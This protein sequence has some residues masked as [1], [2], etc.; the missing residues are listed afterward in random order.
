MTPEVQPVLEANGL[1]VRAGGRTILREVSLHVPAREV[2]AVVGPSGAGKSTLLRCFNRLNDLRPQ[3]A[4]SGSIRFQGR[5]LSEF[6][7][8]DELRRRIGMVFQ[9][10]V[11]FP[12]SVWKNTLF[13]V[14]H[15]NLFPKRRWNDVA[16]S[17]LRGA[18]L[19]DEVKDR[20]QDRATDLSVG[21]Q[22]R[23]ALART[24]AVEPE[25]ILLDEPTSS[26]DRRSTESIE[27]AL[28]F[29]KRTRTLVLVTHDLAQA[30]RVA[31]WVGCVCVRDGAG[32][33]VEAGCCEDFFE[34]PVQK[35][36]KEYL[37]LPTLG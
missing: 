35:A 23:L 25:V 9:R 18:A 11:T 10:P 2:F 33:L 19:W 36:T 34:R 13:G 16:E 22:Q 21:Q 1:T 37:G 5:E 6:H 20:L 15:L 27:E 29:L 30:R 12:G 14:A 31:G 8:V 7:D 4:V 17:A 26:L 24:L 32:E 28:A 3:L